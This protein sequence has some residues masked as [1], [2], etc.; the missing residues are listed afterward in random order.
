MYHY[1]LY[2]HKNNSTGYTKNQF[3]YIIKKS[4]NVKSVHISFKWLLSQDKVG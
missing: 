2:K 3:R 1:V 4:L